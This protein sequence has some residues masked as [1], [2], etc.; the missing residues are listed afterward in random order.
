MNKNMKREQNSPNA[1]QDFIIYNGA[2]IFFTDN[3]QVYHGKLWTAINQ[4]YC[5][6]RGCTVPYHQSSNY[7]KGKGGNRKYWLV[8]LLN[9]T[10][11]A[12]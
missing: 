4:K 8:K 11:H 1:H 12:P 5:I 7:T 9:F 10:P 6:K 3:A 2:P